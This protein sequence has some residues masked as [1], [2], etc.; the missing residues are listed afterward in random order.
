MAAADDGFGVSIDAAESL[1][2]LARVLEERPLDALGTRSVRRALRALERIGAEPSAR[3]AFAASHTLD[4]LPDSLRVVAARAGI[5][6]R[7]RQAPYGQYYQA[8][9]EAPAAGGAPSDDLLV[10]SLALRDIAPA[11]V[12]DFGA[13]SPAAARSERARILE[14]VEEW[15]V[16][17]VAHTPATLVICN[18]PRAVLPGLGIADQKAPVSQAEW[19]MELNLDLLRA[20]RSSERVCVCDLDRVMATYGAERALSERLYYLAKQPWQDGFCLVLAEELLRYVVAAKGWTRKCLVIDLDNTLWGGVTAEDGPAALLVGPGDPVGEAFHDFQH[21]VRELK[22]RGVL[23]A[24]AS[25]NNPDDVDAT[26]RER[27]DMPLALEDFSALRIGWDPKPL[28]VDWI[29]HGLDIGTD[30]LVFFDDNPAER[31]QMLRARPEVR[32]VDVPADVSGY[33][34]SLQSQIWFERLRVTSEDA[35]KARQYE[36]QAQR[37]RAREGAADLR[38]YLQ[39][40]DSQLVVRAVGDADVARVHQLFS[41]TNQFNL[42]T[43]RY[44]LGQVQA[45]ASSVRHRLRVAS[46]RDRHGDLGS[47]GVYLLELQPDGVELA[48]FL[49]SCRALGRGIETA[50]MNC[51]KE[52]A[53][54]LAP[55]GQLAARFQ[56]TRKNAPARGFLEEQGLRGGE[57]APDGSTHCSVRVSK[58]TAI[59]APYIAVRFLRMES[60][61]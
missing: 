28:G 21:A 61:T 1:E 42:T 17:A 35:S 2:D 14:H 37:A 44:S 13:L 54:A 10:L 48:A 59:E 15:A 16:L 38:A 58:L 51:L 50:L 9:A 19:L 40:L 23:L 26:F 45:F 39:E 33:R 12:F 7:T 6:L 46:A 5:A 20:F 52:D 34:R 36:Q 18:F 3:V 11:A 25:K 60:D 27:K 4:P 49:L 43:P 47:I 55:D 8:V 41:K 29:A 57:S 32:V 30:S 31:L 24:A 56:P 22:R 53:R